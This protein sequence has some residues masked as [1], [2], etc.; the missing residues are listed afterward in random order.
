MLTTGENVILSRHKI[1]KT[2]TLK[3]SN[4]KI[5][6]QNYKVETVQFFFNKMLIYVSINKTIFL[7]FSNKLSKTSLKLIDPDNGAE[8]YMNL[9]AI[10]INKETLITF[11]LYNQIFL[12]LTCYFILF[13]NVC[14]CIMSNNKHRCMIT[15]G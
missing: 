10:P 6:K 8:A 1:A 13:A 4:S 14:L 7:H 9:E 12:R 3:R 5:D 2:C 11:S 15:S